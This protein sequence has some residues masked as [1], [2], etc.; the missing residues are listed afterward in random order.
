MNRED[1]EKAACP[2]DLGKS[3]WGFLRLKK[4]LLFDKSV[5]LFPRGSEGKRGSFLGYKISRINLLPAESPLAGQ[6]SPSVSPVMGPSLHRLTQVQRLF[7]S[8]LRSGGASLLLF[9]NNLH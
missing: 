7:S 1:G 8:L 6:A 9:K 5:I 2:G 3:I 4:D